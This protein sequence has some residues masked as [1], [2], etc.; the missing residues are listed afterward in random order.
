MRVGRFVLFDDVLGRGVINAEQTR[1]FFDGGTLNLNNID[2]V[3]ALFRLYLHVAAFRANRTVF[4]LLLAAVSGVSAAGLF[5]LARLA[6]IRRV[7]AAFELS[8][9]Q[10]TLIISKSAGESL[11]RV[12]G[13]KATYL[14]IAIPQRLYI[15]NRVV[16]VTEPPDLPRVYITMILAIFSSCGVSVFAW[17]PMKI[18]CSVGYNRN[19]R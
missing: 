9:A 16:C 17:R 10:A 6:I 13:L 8:R 2:Q 1:G 5:L 11:H 18:I 7:G 15:T 3:C 12:L 19:V 4:C 14:V